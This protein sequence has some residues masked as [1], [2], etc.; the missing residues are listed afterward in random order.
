MCTRYSYRTYQILSE[1]KDT[2]RRE[3]IDCVM[4][5]ARKTDSPQHFTSPFSSLDGPISMQQSA[6]NAERSLLND[7]V[8]NDLLHSVGEQS[9][10]KAKICAGP[11]AAHWNNFAQGPRSDKRQ[12]ALNMPFH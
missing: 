8:Y 9:R 12:S 2:A 1:I 7:S 6:M 3:T 5:G 4:G 11:L 10:R